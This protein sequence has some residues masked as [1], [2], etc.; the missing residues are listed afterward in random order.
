MSNE[1]GKKTNAM[2]AVVSSALPEDEKM[3]VYYSAYKTSNVTGDPLNNLNTVAI[4]GKVILEQEY[5]DCKSYRSEVVENP[6]WLDIAVLANKMIIT[7]QD[8]HYFLEGVNPVTV[9]GINKRKQ[10]KIDGVKVY[11]FS[12]GS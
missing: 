4:R 12:M 1:Y 11:T 2:N 3:Y 8:F 5:D 10:K 6:T 7:T 9:G